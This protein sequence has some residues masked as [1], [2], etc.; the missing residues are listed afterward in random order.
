MVTDQKTFGVYRRLTVAQSTDQMIRKVAQD[1]GAVSALLVQALQSKII[2]GAI[3]SAVSEEKPFFPVPRLATTLQEV[4]GSAGTRYT[5]SP[6]VQALS[7]AAKQNRKALAFVGTPCQIRAIRRMQHANLKL[8]RPIKILVGLMCSKAF[9]YEGLMVD[10]IQNRLGINL[11]SVTRIDIKGKAMT[12]TA[13][14]RETRIPLASVEK[15]AR[16]ACRLCDDFS[17][18]L[19]DISAGSLGLNGWTVLV[20]RTLIGEQVF[21]EAEKAQAFVTRSVR[22]DE[23]AFELLQ[24]LSKTKH[25]RT[26]GP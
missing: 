17:S 5:Y 11:H 1:G 16:K 23:P 10:H 21:T 2:D 14:A 19:A 13:D 20:I 22:E 6:N 9:S 3:V 8:A 18:E 7:E 15:Y 26:E 24:R 25:G 12:I 4:V